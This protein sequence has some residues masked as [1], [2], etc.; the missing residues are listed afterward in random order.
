MHFPNDGLPRTAGHS[1]SRLA[2]SYYATANIPTGEFLA[3][4]APFAYCGH[5]RG[6]YEYEF[7]LAPQQ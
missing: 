2:K 5:V 1:L 4:G 6:G 3:I 7:Y